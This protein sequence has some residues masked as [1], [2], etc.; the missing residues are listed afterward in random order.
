MSYCTKATVKFFI[1]EF[2]DKQLPEAYDRTIF[3]SKCDQTF[4][5]VYDVY[6]G[7]VQ[8]VKA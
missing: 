1:E 3:Q 6:G 7:Y 2:F 8:E 5:H 4:L